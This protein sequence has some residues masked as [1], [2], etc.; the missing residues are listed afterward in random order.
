[1][2]GYPELMGCNIAVRREIFLKVGG[3]KQLPDNLLGIDK[4]F[5]DSLIYLTRLMKKGKIR[6]LNFISVFTSARF[7][8]IHRSL[9]RINQYRSKRKVYH[10]LAKDINWK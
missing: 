4:V 1:L 9:R 8:S 10:N 7:L 5:S 2:V 6:T 3:F